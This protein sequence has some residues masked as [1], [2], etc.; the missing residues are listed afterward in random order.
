[1]VIGACFNKYTFVMSIR[2]CL[3]FSTQIEVG[4]GAEIL[5]FASLHSE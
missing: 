4:S 5:H 2:Y 1:M 3:T